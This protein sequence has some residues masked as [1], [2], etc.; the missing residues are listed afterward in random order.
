MTL[1]LQQEAFGVSPQS[2]ALVVHTVP[3]AASGFSSLGRFVSFPELLVK[4]SA[5]FGAPPLLL[6]SNYN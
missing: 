1:P 2:A 4:M 3:R 5:P 6:G